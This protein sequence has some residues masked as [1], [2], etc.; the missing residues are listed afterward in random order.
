MS[1][2]LDQIPE[3]LLP[4][5]IL[6]QTFKLNLASVSILVIFFIIFDQV[7]RNFYTRSVFVNNPVKIEINYAG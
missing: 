2:L 6:Q 4:A 5:L 1:P 7:Y 3:P